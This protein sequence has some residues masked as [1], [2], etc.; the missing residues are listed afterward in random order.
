MIA[1]KV[2]DHD[3]GSIFQRIANLSTHLFP[4][5]HLDG[6]GQQPLALIAQRQPG[7]DHDTAVGGLYDTG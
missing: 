3:V 5:S 6:M 2:A 1:M 7:I 4:Y